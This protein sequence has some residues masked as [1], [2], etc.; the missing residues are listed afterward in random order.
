MGYSS[1]VS[2][3]IPS[4]ETNEMTMQYTKLY[5][6][7]IIQMVTGYINVF[8]GSFKNI[9]LDTIKH[10]LLIIEQNILT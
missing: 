4:K 1:F 8:F 2:S 10:L 3:N 5:K 6:N 9:V 7:D